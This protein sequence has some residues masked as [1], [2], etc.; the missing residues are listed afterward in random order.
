MKHPLWDHIN[1]GTGDRK[2]NPVLCP[3]RVI[4]TSLGHGWSREIE[5]EAGLPLFTQCNVRQSSFWKPTLL[6][7]LHTEAGLEWFLYRVSAV[8]GRLRILTQASAAMVVH[9]ALLVA[10]AG[11]VEEAVLVA[12]SPRL[13]P[14]EMRCGTHTY[15]CQV[16]S[17]YNSDIIIC[18]T[19]I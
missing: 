16:H 9:A 1:G 10:G 7:D 19:F 3:D 2:W 4:L 8:T 15:A 5:S 12:D 18:I 6:L 11:G 13:E 14:G 17:N